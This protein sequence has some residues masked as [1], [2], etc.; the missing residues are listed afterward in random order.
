MMMGGVGVDNM[1]V[2]HHNLFFSIFVVFGVP[3]SNG[4]FNVLKFIINESFPM[5]L[6]FFMIIL[7]TVL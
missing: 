1:M 7:T 6:P 2:G 3:F 5:L 4:R